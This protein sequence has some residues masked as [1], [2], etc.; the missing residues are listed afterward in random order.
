MH[1]GAGQMPKIYTDELGIKY[2]KT[3][4]GNTV[5]VSQ[6]AMGRISMVDAA[7][8]L[9]YDTGDKRLGAYIVSNQGQLHISKSFQADPCPVHGCLQHKDI[10]KPGLSAMLLSQQCV[11]HPAFEVSACLV[12]IDLATRWSRGAAVLHRWTPTTTCT[13]CSSTAT[14]KSSEQKWAT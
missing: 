1:A 4:G 2:L 5:A 6:D 12:G 7:G 14:A 11:L 3:A 10:I 8:N 9:Y 13:T